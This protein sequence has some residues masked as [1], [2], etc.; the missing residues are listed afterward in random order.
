MATRIRF[1]ELYFSYDEIETTLIANLLEDSGISCIIRDMRITPYPLT[2]GVFTER[3]VAVEEDR[4]EEARII[5]R[6]AIRDGFISGTGR[7]KE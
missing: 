4:V 7:F 6:D 3:R 2:I 1:V 5:I